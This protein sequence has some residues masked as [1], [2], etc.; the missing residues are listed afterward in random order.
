[1]E[2]KA[3]HST[4]DPKQAAQAAHASH[5]SLDDLRKRGV[6][7][8]KVLTPD[9]V[10]ELI[11]RRASDLVTREKTRIIAEAQAKIRP[12]TGQNR[13]LRE[14]LEALTGKLEATQK[15]LESERTKSFQQGAES[16]KPIV[17]RYQDQVLALKTR[18]KELEEDNRAMLK[19]REEQ[20]RD[21]LTQYR[22]Q[23]AQLAE[24][25]KR[26]RT[27]APTPDTPQMG[28]EILKQFQS[29]ILQ[30]RQQISSIADRDNNA[31]EK[32][33]Q[34]VTKM[35][36]GLSDRIKESIDRL[37]T[38][39]KVREPVL[40]KE[41]ILDNL[42]KDL[43]ETNIG[44]MKVR[45]NN[46]QAIDGNLEKLKGFHEGREELELPAPGSE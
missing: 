6:K 15:L 1:M 5:T 33:K 38:K 28:K 14:K 25:I 12:L 35:E 3:S 41:V 32:M 46:G 34:M 10:R 39:D 44:A 36:K 29:E 24:D 27:P 31:S 26:V 2:E 4:T 9:K 23:I 37:K 19:Q 8:V 21:A 18:I 11:N 42:F 7:K 20:V 30:L 43:P 13:E 22:E 45:Q 16:Q 40:P 17:E